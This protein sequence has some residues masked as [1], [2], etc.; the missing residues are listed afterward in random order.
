MADPFLGSRCDPREATLLKQHATEFLR[1]DIATFLAHVMTGSGIGLNK[2]PA[3][4][5]IVRMNPLISPVKNAGAWSAAG[6]GCPVAEDSCE[7][8]VF[9]KP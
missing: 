4:S 8:P 9:R 7:F 5:R 2:P 1:K 3:D 6:G